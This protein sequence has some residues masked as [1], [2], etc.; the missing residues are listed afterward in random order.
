MHECNLNLG[1]SL[2]DIYEITHKEYIKG[3]ID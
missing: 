1:L 2:E 3:Q